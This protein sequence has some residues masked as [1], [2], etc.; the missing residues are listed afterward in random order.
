[1]PTTLDVR[2]ESNVDRL[3]ARRVHEGIVELAESIG[4]DSADFMRVIV[5][6]DTGR[7][8][9]HVGHSFFEDLMG[10]MEVRVGVR[11]IED[12]AVKRYQT[13]TKDLPVP[14]E[15][16]AEYYPL[17]VDRGTGIFGETGTP[18]FARRAHNMR[19]DDAEG[20]TIFRHE[21]AGQ[22]PAHFMLETYAAARVFVRVAEERFFTRLKEMSEEARAHL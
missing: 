5:P 10:R 6:K 19:F 21:V 15:Q 22:R 7:L 2:V 4:A 11:P 1:M 13:A 16:R 8:A 17:Y 18:I 9:E 14:G 12:A 20:V 3:S